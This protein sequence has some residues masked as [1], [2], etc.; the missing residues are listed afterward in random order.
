MGLFASRGKMKKL[1]QNADSHNVKEK[2]KLKRQQT[3]RHFV[4]AFAGDRDPDQVAHTPGPPIPQSPIPQSPIPYPLSAVPIFSPIQ[5][6]TVDGTTLAKQQSE[7]FM[8]HLQSAW[9]L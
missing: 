8:E 5:S 9:R 6:N 7:L 4:V 1:R 2:S 3:K